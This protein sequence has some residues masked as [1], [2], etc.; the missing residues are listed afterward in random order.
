MNLRKRIQERRAERDDMIATMQ[1]QDEEIAIF[2]QRHPRIAARLAN[3]IE[4]RAVQLVEK[5]GESEQLTAG[6]DT[7]YSMTAKETLFA[8]NGNDEKTYGIVI[9][10][11][12]AVVLK[13]LI[14]AIWNYV[15]E[16]FRD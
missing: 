11:I 14:E 7:P 5:A 15:V 2:F 3:R 6:S 16:R 4:A 8:E 12:A 9:E 13:K 1:E 10:A